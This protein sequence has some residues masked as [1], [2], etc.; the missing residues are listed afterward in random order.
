[1]LAAEFEVVTAHKTTKRLTANVVDTNG[2]SSLIFEVN[3]ILFSY[4]QTVQPDILSPLYRVFPASPMNLPSCSA[5]APL[6][7]F[8]SHFYYSQFVFILCSNQQ[9]NTSIQRGGEAGQGLGSGYIKKLKCCA[10][11]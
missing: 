3:S 8:D 2:K 11:E 9:R 6:T 7:L 4:S 1:M 10:S 5:C